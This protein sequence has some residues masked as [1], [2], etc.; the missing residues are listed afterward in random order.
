[1]GRLG[2]NDLLESESL[3]RSLDRAGSPE[4]AGAGVARLARLLADSGRA[5]LAAIY[6]RQLAGRFAGVVC[7]EGKTGQQL[8][9][10]L[11]PAGPLAKWLGPAK[12]WPQGN[13]MAREVQLPSRGPQTRPPRL[14]DLEI[15]GPSAPFFQETTIS[16]D[17]NA[18]MLLGQD[19]LGEKRFRIPIYEQHGRPVATNRYGYNAPPLSYVSVNGGLLVLSMS[20][21]VMAIDTVRGSGNAAN[22]ILWS[23]D[24]S[25]Q[26]GGFPTSQGIYSR[27]VPAP[28]GAT[29]YVPEDTFLRRYGSIGPVTDDGVYFQRLRDLYCVDPLTGKTVWMRKNVGLGNQLFGDEELLLVAPPGDEDTLVLRASTGESLGARRIASF[30]KRMATVG[31]MVLSWEPEGAHQSMQMRDP[32][33]GQTLWSHPVASGSKAALVSQE[34][35]GVLQPDGMFALILLADGKK[36]VEQKLEPENSLIGIYI[37]RSRDQYLLI[38]NS[39][40]R[41]EP[42]SGVQPAPGGV[43]NPLVNGR[44][45]AFDRQTGQ[46]SWPAPAVVSQYGLIMNQPSQLPVL[47]LVRQ[48][49]RPSPSATRELKTSVLCID[50]RTGR[51]AYEGDQLPLA[52]GGNVEL[53]GD[54]TAHTVTLTLASKAVELT[55]TDEPP[56]AAPPGDTPPANAP[57][58]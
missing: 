1:M 12:P 16:L 38:T 23:Q 48:L 39:A 13:A 43:N 58:K 7:Q 15:V 9:A 33:Q 20:N 10:E 54:P 53:S 3:V 17:L 46:K 30:D 44:V 47:V 21:Q 42:N 2:G 29:R 14:V 35:V 28:W 8:V 22:R 34:A 40:A 37:L 4:Q 24:L 6:Y 45:Y 32:W 26:I 5:D 25:D 41:N 19:G 49:H 18:Q 57:A 36:L 50:K 56:A 27:P 31:R 55:F 51:V 11:P 52:T